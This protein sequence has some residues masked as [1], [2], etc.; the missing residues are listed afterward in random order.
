MVIEIKQHQS[1]NEYFNKIRLYLK[2][3]INNLEKSD[4]WKIQ[5][6]IANESISSLDNIEEQVKVITYKS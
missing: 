4:T 2:D 6:T 1:K 3:I 5:L